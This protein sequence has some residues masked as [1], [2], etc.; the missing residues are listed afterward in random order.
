MII[1]LFEHWKFYD[2]VDK[3]IRPIVMDIFNT[4]RD[5][6]KVRV[7]KFSAQRQHKQLGLLMRV[8]IEPVNILI[9][10]KHVVDLCRDISTR[11]N[12]EYID[13]IVNIIVASPRDPKIPLPQGANPRYKIFEYDLDEYNGDIPGYIKRIDICI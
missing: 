11:L 13:N 6:E 2:E 9:D 12:N 10:D 5:D 1:K 8:T 7:S 4:S 3:D